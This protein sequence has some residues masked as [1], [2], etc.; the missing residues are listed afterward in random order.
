MSY[1]TLT[2][3]YCVLIPPFSSGAIRVYPETTLLTLRGELG[4]LLG[5]EKSIHKF[6]FLKCVGR[7]LAL[8][9]IA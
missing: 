1:D 6:S 4:A 5:I 7:S 2:G 3:T 8:V 9:S